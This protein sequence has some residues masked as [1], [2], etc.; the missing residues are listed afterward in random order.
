MTAPYRLYGLE[1]ASAVVL[2]RDPATDPLAPGAPA[3]TPRAALEGVL[4]EALQRPPC[5]I[6]FSGGRDS[7]GLLALALHV[8]R[9]RGLPAP[10][11]A[12]NVFP[13]DE[14]SSEAEWQEL[15]MR[16]VRAA[17][18]ERLEFSDELDLIGPVA[19]AALR[20]WG[21]VPLQRPL[22]ASNLPLG[23]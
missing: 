16:H 13:G 19:R 20:Q 5:V 1:L 9:A 21:P 12:T 4:A 22:R 2:G 3:V 14:A 8:A 11:A 6:G 7:S 10:V 18:W 17:D 15:V 23:P